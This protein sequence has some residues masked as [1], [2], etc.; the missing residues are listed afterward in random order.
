MT[1]LEI[2][3]QAERFVNDELELKE[4]SLHIRHAR[5]RHHDRS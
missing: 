4:N 3:E 2:Q 1:D 5:V